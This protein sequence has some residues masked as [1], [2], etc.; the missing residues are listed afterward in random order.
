M[1]NSNNNNEAMLKKLDD[2]VERLD[3]LVWLM[4]A[5]SRRENA[6]LWAQSKDRSHKEM[7]QLEARLKE[8]ERLG[9]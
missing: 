9:K 6:E 1:N 5:M 3:K 7:E 4:W 2:I 8:L